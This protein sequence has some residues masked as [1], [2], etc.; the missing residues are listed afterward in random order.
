VA[1]ALVKALKSK[2]DSVRAWAALRSGD[3]PTKQKE[4]EVDRPTEDVL[5]VAL[6]KSLKDKEE[7]VREYAAV[8][9][10]KRKDKAAVPALIERVADD[11]WPQFRNP[12]LGD[13]R[14]ADRS[15][16]KEAALAALKALAADRVAGALIKARKCKNA[17]IRQWATT[18]LGNS[19]KD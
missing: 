2:N 14:N 5:T 10:Q 9:L 18:E 11:V 13:I 6:S 16:S 17:T 19:K 3:L 7:K 12:I 8:S 15:E 4:E 1:D